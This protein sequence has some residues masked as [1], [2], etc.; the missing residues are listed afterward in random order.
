M[1]PNNSGVTIV[2]QL[3]MG[4]VEC[5]PRQ[6]ML[7]FPDRRANCTGSLL[8]LDGVFSGGAAHLFPSRHPLLKVTANYRGL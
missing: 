5:F 7:D 1:C 4:V 6:N 2:G 3:G 8:N